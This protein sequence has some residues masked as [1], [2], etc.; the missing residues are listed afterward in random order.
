[1]VAED[2]AA[3]SD[4]LFSISKTADPHWQ[5]LLPRLMA[6]GCTINAMGSEVGITEQFCLYYVVYLEILPLHSFSSFRFSYCFRITNLDV[7][8]SWPL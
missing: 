4:S 7:K 2:L 8:C 3:Y 6:L 1:M 5:M